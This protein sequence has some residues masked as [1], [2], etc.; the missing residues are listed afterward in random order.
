MT[1]DVIERVNQMAKEQGLTSDKCFDQKGKLMTSV[2]KGVGDTAKN[3][4]DVLGNNDFHQANLPSEEENPGLLLDNYQGDD[5]LSNEE[6]DI[7]EAADLV[8]DMRQNRGSPCHS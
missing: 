8:E 2:V 5:Q 1:E 4:N 7:G 6:L 3:L